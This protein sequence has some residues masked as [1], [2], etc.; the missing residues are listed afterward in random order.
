MHDSHEWMLHRSSF[1]VETIDLLEDLSLDSPFL[2]PCHLWLV[3]SET[4]EFVDV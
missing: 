1:P 4:D 3:N 2:I